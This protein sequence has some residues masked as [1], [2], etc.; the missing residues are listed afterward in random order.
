MSHN[1]APLCGTAFFFYDGCMPFLWL[2][3]QTLVASAGI[4]CPS[5]EPC[6]PAVGLLRSP[7]GA[8]CTVSWVEGGFMLTNRHCL[9]KAAQKKSAS[10]AGVSF[11]FPTIDGP[12][13]RSFPATTIGCQSVV[14]LSST[15]TEGPAVVPDIALLKPEHRLERPDL[16]VETNGVV[17]DSSLTVYAV[18]PVVAEKNTALIVKRDCIARHGSALLPRSEEPLSPVFAVSNCTLSGGNSGAPLLNTQGKLVGAVHGG[19]TDSSLAA[20]SKSL[21]RPI[22]P[23]HIASAVHCVRSIDRYRDVSSHCGELNPKLPP[24]KLVELRLSIEAL[25]IDADPV[26]RKKANEWGGKGDP[27]L[28]EWKWSRPKAEPASS[29]LR[30][31]LAP[32]C[33]RIQENSPARLAALSDEDGTVSFKVRPLEAVVPLTF[34]PFLRMAPLPA[35]FT[36]GDE[37]FIAFERTEIL[38]HKEVTVRMTR[39]LPNRKR[40]EVLR[41]WTIKRCSRDSS[42]F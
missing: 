21:G 40:F 10:C 26:F 1:A 17:N 15:P 33:I 7:S 13:G 16:L 24:D 30:L 42:V 11:E 12:S 39:A 28:F 5:S 2:I 6:H 31:E 35:Q 23:M 22:E 19:F 8:L 3:L 29:Q 38:E 14:E 25:R 36:D 32:R 20:L 37:R 41:E 9:P 27:S 4:R 18:E 34:D